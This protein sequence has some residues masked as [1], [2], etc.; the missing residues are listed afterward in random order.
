MHVVVDVDSDAAVDADE[1]ALE[2]EKWSSAVPTDK[3]TV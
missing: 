3:R 1:L 2:V